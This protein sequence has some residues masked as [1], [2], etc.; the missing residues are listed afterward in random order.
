MKANHLIIDL[1]QQLPWHRR[2]ASST[3]TALMWAVWLLLWR[4][5]L[6]VAG[7]VS[8]QKHHVIQQLFGAFG[9]GVE[10]GVLALFAAATALLLW[11]NYMPGRS[12]QDLPRKQL[13][14]YAKH[15]ELPVQEIEQGREQKISV[16]HHDEYGK[17]I[18]I[19]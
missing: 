16:V 1:R 2:Y 6:I 14:D 4:P 10:H 17:I 18:R 3:G 11:A 5:L 15:F 13:T 9:L 19:D 7:L 12:V 8:L